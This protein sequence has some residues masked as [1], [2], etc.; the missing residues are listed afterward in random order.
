M[1]FTLS[2]FATLQ[3]KLRE[4]ANPI[5]AVSRCALPIS[6]GIDIAVIER[7]KANVRDAAFVERLLTNREKAYVFAK[8][9]PHRHLAGR[10]AAKEAVMKALGTGWDKGVGWKDIEVVN[11]SNGRPCAALRSKAASFAAGKEIFLSIAYTKEAACAFAV[12]ST[13]IVPTLRRGNACGAAA[14]SL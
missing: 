5:Y 9:R 8:R 12:I 13:V 14:R 10:F 2:T 4:R 11:D 7:F 3:C 6:S 1:E